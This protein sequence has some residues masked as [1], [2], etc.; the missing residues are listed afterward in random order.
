VELTAADFA[1]TI[2]AARGE[3]IVRQQNAP[4]AGC[5]DAHDQPG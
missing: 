5:L 2:N 4:F 3:L 1:R